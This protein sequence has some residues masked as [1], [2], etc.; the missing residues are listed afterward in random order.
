MIR[1]AVSAGYAIQV[2]TEGRSEKRNVAVKFG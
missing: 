1:I 2:V